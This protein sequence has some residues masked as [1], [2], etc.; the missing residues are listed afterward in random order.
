LKALCKVKGNKITF[1]NPGLLSG[2]Y[3]ASVNSKKIGNIGKF[4]VVLKKKLNK[5]SVTKGTAGKTDLK[6]YG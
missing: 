5:I 3:K 1:K 6:F 2:N 4:K